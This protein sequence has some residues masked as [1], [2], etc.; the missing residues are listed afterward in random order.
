MTSNFL[1]L[2]LILVAF[3]AIDGHTFE[4]KQHSTTDFEFAPMPEIKIDPLQNP[5][6]RGNSKQLN[7]IAD[8]FIPMVILAHTLY[9]ERDITFYLPLYELHRSQ[10]LFLRI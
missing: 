1:R 8:P 5:T 3:L 9:D 6:S 10:Q 2:F 7:Y 4:M